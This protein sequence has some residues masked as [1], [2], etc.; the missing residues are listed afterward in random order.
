MVF[1]R[2]MEVYAATVAYTFT[3]I[4]KI[5]TSLKQLGKEN[6]SIIIVPSGAS[7]GF[8]PQGFF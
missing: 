4:S 1:E 8:S 3:E 7:S 5:Y 2:M 6:V